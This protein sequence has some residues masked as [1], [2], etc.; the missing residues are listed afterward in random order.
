[1]SLESISPLIFSEKLSLPWSWAGG[2]VRHVRAPWRGAGRAGR[3]IGGIPSCLS[4]MSILHLGRVAASIK[5]P[6]WFQLYMVRDRAFMH[7]LLDEAERVGLQALWSS[8]W[9]CQ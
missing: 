9:I 7:R 3:G 2:I 4:T 8:Q 6:L 1:M 5:R